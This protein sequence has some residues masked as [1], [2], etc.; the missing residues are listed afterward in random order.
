MESKKKK[1]I[2][3]AIS[4]LLATGAIV[5]PAVPYVVAGET[6]D[7]AACK[8]AGGCA[9]MHAAEHAEE[10]AAKAADA[11]EEEGT[12]EAKEETASN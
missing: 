9:G 6:K 3:A 8:G 7:A 4:G 10:G 2:A 5:L 11:V 1:F 12:D